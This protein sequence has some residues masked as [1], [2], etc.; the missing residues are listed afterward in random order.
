M[1]E[2]LTSCCTISIPLRRRCEAHTDSKINNNL[3]V[4]IV[5]IRSLPYLSK[6]IIIVKERDVKT[7]SKF[8]FSYKLYVGI[9]HENN[10]TS[11]LRLSKRTSSP[12]YN[13][14]SINIAHFLPV[15]LFSPSPLMVAQILGIKSLYYQ[16]ERGKGRGKKGK[17]LFMKL[18][19]MG[20]CWFH[21]VELHFPKHPN[22]GYPLDPTS[23][24][25]KKKGSHRWEKQL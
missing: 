9:A 25:K 12:F 21:T 2:N 3:E 14:Y 6:P 24:L 11:F 13:A 18:P 7:I 20:I 1:L 23:K 5:T 8:L 16:M 15:N 17:T 19:F 22:Y 4:T 10:I